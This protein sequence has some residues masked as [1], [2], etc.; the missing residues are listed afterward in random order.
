MIFIGALARLLGAG[1]IVASGGA[2]A[3]FALVL[4]G[5][6]TLQQGMGGRRRRR[7]AEDDAQRR[8]RQRFQAVGHDAH[9]EEEQPD[10]AENGN[11]CRHAHAFGFEFAGVSAPAGWGVEALSGSK[12]LAASSHQDANIGHSLLSR[13]AAEA[14]V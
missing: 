1:R 5:L 2:L 3:G 6:T 4:Y 7:L 11:C 8:S 10:A 12:T 9:A 13:Y 14:S